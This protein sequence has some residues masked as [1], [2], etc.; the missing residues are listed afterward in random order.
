[1][2]NEKQG[3]EDQDDFNAYKYTPDEDDEFFRVSIQKELTSPCSFMITSHWIVNARLD[4]IK[5]I[6]NAMTLLG[7]QLRTAYLSVAYFDKFLSRRM[8]DNE[9]Y[10]AVRLLSV[11]CL[12]LAA[13]MEEYKVPLLKDFPMEDYYFE[14]KVI[15]RM[16][17]P[18][19]NVVPTDLIYAIIND[20]NLMSSRSSVIAAAATLLTLDENL[21]RQSMDTKIKTFA[22]GF[23]ET[24]DV[25]HCY[26]RMQELSRD[27]INLTPVQCIGADDYGNSSSA[28][29]INNKRKRLEFDVRDQDIVMPTEKGRQ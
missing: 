5:W 18:P 4:S 12:S 14:G 16:E 17:D 3:E 7:F 10:W 25:F 15:Q 9:K 22:C 19:R 26:N 13:K 27:K 8:I 1:M 2:D 21:T 11:A 20:L 6:F 23:V 24:E 29:V 28:P